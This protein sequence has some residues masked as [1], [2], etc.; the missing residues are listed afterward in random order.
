MANFFLQS[1]ESAISS[2][3]G[4]VDKYANVVTTGHRLLISPDPYNVLIAFNPTMAF[5]QK[6]EKMISNHTGSESF[7]PDSNRDI[8][9]VPL[10]KS[11]VALTVLIQAMCRTL[12]IIPVHQNE[13]IRMIEMV[14]V[15]YYDKILAR[16]RTLMAGDQ[17]HEDYEGVGIISAGWACEDEIVQLLLKNTYFMPGVP[18]LEINKA[19]AESGY[20][21]QET[22]VEMSFKRERSFSRGELVFDLRKLQDLAH[23]HHSMDWFIAQIAHLRVTEKSVRRIPPLLKPRISE[24]LES[25][26]SLNDQR[27]S[28]ESLPPLVVENEDDVQ[29]PLNKEMTSRFDSIINYYQELSETYLFAL[30]VELRCHAMYYLDLA[31]REGSYY[32]ENEPYEPDSYINSLNQDLIMIQETVSSAL[33]LRKIR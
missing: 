8:S 21:F 18:N 5:V 11:A 19:L 14:L 31:M 30:R 24:S 1:D 20:L 17:L 10:V 7:V 27:T 12:F 22:Y 6:I 9:A 29:L 23:M 15:K 33:P 25:S 16:Y 26:A 28:T 2:S 13:F 3:T 32:L 4:V